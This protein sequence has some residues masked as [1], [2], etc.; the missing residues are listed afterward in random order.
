MR[1][2][3]RY[4]SPPRHLFGLSLAR[5]LSS[6]SAPELFLLTPYRLPTQNTLYLGDDDVAAFLNG[7]AALWHPAALVGAAGPPRPASPYDHEQ[8]G[9]HIYALPE[10]PPLM[11][12]DDW[13]QR[14]RQAG[15]VFFRASADRDATFANLIEA[16]TAGKRTPC[17]A[18]RL[19]SISTQCALRLFPAS[20]S[21]FYKLK[22]CARR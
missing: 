5:Y 7:Y 21:G 13:E 8:P 17:P 14:A 18:G 10:S 12:P 11:L 16:C 4:L 6:M 3:L 2:S 22:P 1:G 19:C 15:A 20:G 9:P